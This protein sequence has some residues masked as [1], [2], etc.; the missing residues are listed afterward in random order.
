M[1]SE[2]F[3]SASFNASSPDTSPAISFSMRL[4][5]ETI[6]FEFGK[7]AAERPDRK[8]PPRSI[9]CLSWMRPLSVQ[10]LFAFILLKSLTTVDAS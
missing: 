4:T 7:F 8:N 1:S 3:F 5:L 9:D 10:L 6:R 2:A